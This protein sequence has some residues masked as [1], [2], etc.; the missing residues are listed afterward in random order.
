[1]LPI[2]SMNIPF[3]LVAITAQRSLQFLRNFTSNWQERASIN[4]PE[5]VATRRIIEFINVWWAEMS[6]KF[7]NW[8]ES[9]SSVIITIESVNK[10]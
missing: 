7:V 1:M 3:C 9:V 10:G 5:F 6:G 4:S 8:S 2:W